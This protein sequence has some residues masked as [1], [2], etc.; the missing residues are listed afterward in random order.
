MVLC[1][2]NQEGIDV[3]IS[4]Y[5]TKA[6]LSRKSVKAVLIQVKNAY[7]PPSFRKEKRV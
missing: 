5:H 3:V 7:D 1:S 4:I 6:A 2:D